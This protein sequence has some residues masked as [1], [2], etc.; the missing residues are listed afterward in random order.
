MSATPIIAGVL[1]AIGVIGGAVWFF[2]KRKW[3]DGSK[4]PS[5]E[6]AEEAIKDEWRPVIESRRNGGRRKKYTKKH[7]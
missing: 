7:K 6:S 1:S 3:S 4:I 2:K 5:R